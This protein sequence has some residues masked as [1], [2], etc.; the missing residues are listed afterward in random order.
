M[1]ALS[2]WRSSRSPRADLLRRFASDRSA[3]LGLAIIAIIAI[4]GVAAPWLSPFDPNAQALQLRRAEPSREHV[5]GMDELG[6]DILSRLMYGAGNTLVAGTMAVLVGAAVG[7]PLGLIAGY[8]GRYVEAVIMRAIDAMLAFPAFLLAIVI[9]AVLGPSLE[10]ATLAIGIAQIPAFTRLVRGSVL[11]VRER[12]FV[13]GAVAVGA[14][15]RDIMVR[16]IL[17][18]VMPSIIVLSTV[19]LANAVL[20]IAGLSFLGLGAQPPAA[21]WGVMLRSGREYIRD[22]PHLTV[23]PGV[24]IVALVLSFNLIGDGLRDAL[25]PRL[26]RR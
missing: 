19:S 13:M 26:A 10:N 20:S 11:S 17:P 3:L 8:Y 21:E 22:A 4:V 23:V 16:H 2:R 1:S 15:G 25:D 14:R 12:E 24:A 6:R 5:L 18:N 7:V 9:V